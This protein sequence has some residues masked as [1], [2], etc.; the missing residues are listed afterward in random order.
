MVCPERPGLGSQRGYDGDRENKHRKYHWC[1]P[2]N[3]MRTTDLCYDDKTVKEWWN[4]VWP[5]WRT[6]FQNKDNAWAKAYFCSVYK[7]LRIDKTIT[8]AQL[9]D[10]EVS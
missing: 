9:T 2:V 5:T 10:I 6:W 3:D 7:Q 1:R 4:D 8:D